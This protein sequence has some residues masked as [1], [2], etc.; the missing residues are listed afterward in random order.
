VAEYWVLLVSVVFGAAGYL[1]ATFWFQPLLR[2]RDV[3]SRVLADLIFYANAV[4]TE[5]LADR[6]QQR[7]RDRIEANRRAAADLRACHAALPGWY[8]RWLRRRGEDRCRAAL[9]MMR[10]SNTA[11]YEHATQCVNSIKLHLRINI[12]DL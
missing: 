5:R 1:I 9:G 10:L 6:M 11:D 3:K 12:D 4:K 8:A 2:Y 7:E